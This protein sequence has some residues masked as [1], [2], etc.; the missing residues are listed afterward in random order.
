MEL[1]KNWEW[2]QLTNAS[3]FRWEEGVTPF[4]DVWIVWAF[5]A[6][7]LVVIFGLQEIMK[8]YK[9]LA[10]TN[11]TRIHNVILCVWSLAMCVGIMFPSYQLYKEHGVRALMCGLGPDNMSLMSGAFTFWKYHYYLSKFYELLDTVIMVLKKKQLIFLHVYHHA[12]M[13]YISWIWVSAN[14]TISWWGV[15]T[16][17]LVHVFMYYYYFVATYGVQPWFKQYITSGQIVQFIVGIA[18]ACAH[19]YEYYSSGGNCSGNIRLAWISHAVTISFLFLFINFYIKTY[20][21]KRS[22]RVGGGVREGPAVG[23]VKHG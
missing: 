6:G 7:Y 14:Y 1:E 11:A 22:A 19:I 10:M 21:Q 17:T 5:M 23:K 3:K 2:G 15:L 13:L 8:G 12:S 16:N 4:S 9:P 20:T 18:L